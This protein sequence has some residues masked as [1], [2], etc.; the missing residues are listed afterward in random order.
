MIKAKRSKMGPP[1]AECPLEDCLN[2]LGGA[3]TTKILWYLRAE[4]RRFGDLKRDLGGISA[5]VLTTRL[6][7]LEDRG[8]VARQ[9]LPTSPPT[10]EYSLTPFGFKFQPVLDAI[11]E[12]GAELQR[13]QRIP[14]PARNI[15]IC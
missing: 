15:S 7:E 2:F 4:P 9:V 11:V 14:A 8:V 5:K 12:V 13:R 1:P 3:W 6:R 10:V